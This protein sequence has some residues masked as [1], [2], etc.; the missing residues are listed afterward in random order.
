VNGKTPDAAATP[1]DNVAAIDG[2]TAISAASGVAPRDVYLML[3][4]ADGHRAFVA[5][6]RASR[7]DLSRRYSQSSLENA[8]FKQTVDLSTL[9]NVL[10][11]SVAR[12]VEGRLEVCDNLS[13]RLAV[14]DRLVAQ[15]PGASSPVAVDNCDGSV[16]A[17]NGAKPETTETTASSTV[18]IAGWAAVSAREGV[19]PEDVFIRLETA[20]QPKLYAKAHPQTRDD[21]V[22]V[23]GQPA[24]R[25]AGFAATID[26]SELSGQYV[27]G[28]L[29]LQHGGLETCGNLQYR[30]LLGGKG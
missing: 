26:T 12:L 13:V 20:G 10:A 11:I 30:L 18:S 4:T 19:L 23:Y 22:A 1:V 5:T 29:Q 3:T 15:V 24:L 9:P 17:I 6:E 28:I 2:W 14:Y 7:P 21:L 8:G 27:L 25:K 16:D